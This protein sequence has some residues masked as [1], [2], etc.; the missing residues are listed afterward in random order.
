M[1]RTEIKR[2]EWQ[3]ELLERFDTAGTLLYRS[4]ELGEKNLELSKK[5]V[6]LSEKKRRNCRR[7]KLTKEGL[8]VVVLY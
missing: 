2:A 6:E 4:V 8:E 3:Q 7:D 5:N 1:K